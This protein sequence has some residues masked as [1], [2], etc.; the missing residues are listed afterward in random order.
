MEWWSKQTDFG[1]KANVKWLSK[2]RFYSNSPVKLTVEEDG[3]EHVF[4]LIPKKGVCEAKMKIRGERFK[5]KFYSKGL[6]T[7]ISAPELEFLYYL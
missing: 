2:V 7:E 3:N 6:N 5:L 1:I 4:E